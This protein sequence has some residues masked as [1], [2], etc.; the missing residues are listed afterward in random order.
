MP[1][2]YRNL[3]EAFLDQVANDPTF[4]RRIRENPQEA[5]KAAGF[6]QVLEPEGSHQ[7]E[8]MG[9]SQ[10][11]DTCFNYWTCLSDSCHITI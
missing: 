3:I 1:D 10:C 7:A 4:R 8:V 5:L 9:Y 2:G 6:G 11:L